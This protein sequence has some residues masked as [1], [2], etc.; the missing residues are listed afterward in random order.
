MNFSDLA[1][2]LVVGLING[3]FY[4]LMSL[5]V[6]IIFGTLRVAN[7]VHGAQYMLGAFCAWILMNLPTLFPGLGLPSLGFW[8]ALFL[9]PMIVGLSGVIVEFLLIRRVY[10]LDH[11]YGL[12]LTIG[13]TLVIEGLFRAKF[14]ASALPYGSPRE[15]AGVIDFGFLYLPFYRGLIIVFSSVICFGT[16]ILIEKTSLGATLRAATENPS[17]VRAFGVNVPMLRTVIYGFGVALAGLAGMTAAPIYAV[18]PL[19]GQNII[20]IVFAVVVIGGMGSIL[21]AIL[22]GFS[23]GILEALTKVVWPEASSTTIFVVMAIVLFVKPAGL[24]GRTDTV[25]FRSENSGA[26]AADSGIS[27]K[28]IWALILAWTIIAPF[29][30][31]PLLV[32][33]ILCFALFASAYNLLFGYVGLLSFGHAAF[34]GIASYVTSESAKHWGLTPELAI[35]LGAAVSA[36]VGLIFGWIAIRRKDLYFAMITLALAQIVYFYGVQAK[37]TGGEDGLQGIPRGRA[38]GFIDLN[39]TFN[40]YAFVSIICLAGLWAIYRIINSPFGE[41]LKSIHGNEAR[42]VSLGYDVDRFKLTAFVLSAALSGVAGG[43]KAIVFQLASLVD[44]HYQTSA[45]VL[46]V[47]LMGGIGT[48]LGPIVGSVIFITLQDQLVQLGSWVLIVQG[49]IFIFFVLLF[50]EGIV[51]SISSELARR[52]YRNAT[53]TKPS[54]QS[55]QRPR[56]A[57]DA[58]IP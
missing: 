47:T 31:Y 50:R 52:R 2:Q 19:M 4:A 14:G 5:G 46:L 54:S 21:G 25:S 30:M 29:F 32:L 56:A 53:A 57:E 33:K 40:L 41:V 42:A 15:L 16:W 44:L 8:W 26:L 51:G 13:L 17:L 45:D 58:V 24:L 34:F 48:F 22:A 11:A 6:A 39:D 49:A 27:P 35:L 3:S 28:A 9:V 20:V 37:W 38:F 7:F 36:L 12:L 18:S 1:A 55:S 23:L 43:A 10:A